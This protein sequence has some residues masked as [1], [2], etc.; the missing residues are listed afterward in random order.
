MGERPRDVEG[1]ND[2]V[3][4]DEQL[5]PDDSPEATAEGGLTENPDWEPDRPSEEQEKDRLEP[6]EDGDQ[7]PNE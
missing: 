4:E 5:P 7:E 3:I 6:L 1:G 2:H